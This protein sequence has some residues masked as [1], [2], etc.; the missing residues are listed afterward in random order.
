MRAVL[1]ILGAMT[2]QGPVSQ[3]VSDHRKHHAFSDVEGDPHS[4][5]VGF[6]AG[7]LGAVRGLWHSHVGW[8][9]STKGLVVRTRFG[10]DLTAD[11]LLRVID[12]MYFVWVALGFAIPYAIGYSI[13][14]VSGGVQAMVW[15]G[16][17]RIALFQHVTWSVNSICHMFGRRTTRRATRAA[18][19]GCSRC[20]RSARH[21]TTTTTPSRPPPCTASTTSSSTSRAS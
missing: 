6:G 5:H 14:G 20:R 18:T 2:T 9:F 15:G 7:V 13:D 4:P 16:L 11:R 1:A 8:L 12:R 21:G 10:R 19:T 17:I 3:W